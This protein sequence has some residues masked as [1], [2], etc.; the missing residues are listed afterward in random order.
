M[1][2]TGCDIHKKTCH[3]QHLD[4]D[5]ALGLSKNV[6]TTREAFAKFLARLDGPTTMTLEA[7]R[8]YWWISQFFAR[9]PKVSQTNVVDSRRG[10]KLAEE[11]SVRRGYGRAK[12][13][14]I[15][16]EMLAEQTRC[17]LAPTIHVPTP[18][19]LAVR[20]LNRHHL[21][22]RRLKTMA[23]NRIHGILSMHG[24][25][26][27]IQ[28]LRNQATQRDQLLRELPGYVELFVT[29]MLK[30][31]ELFDQQTVQC[32]QELDKILPASNPTIKLL[33]TAPGIGIVLARTIATEILDPSYL[34]E[35][36]Y[37]LSYAGL[38]PLQNESAGKKGPMQLNQ[39]CNYYLKYAFVAAAHG[40]RTHPRYRRKYEQD[41]KQHGKIRAK[42]NLAR[43]LAK[44][45]Y[46][47]LTRQQPYKF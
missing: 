33:M 16:A 9:H 7:T 17:G 44:A 29:N 45:V 13:D 31:M 37:L 23:A 22:L 42:L 5:G 21:M 4:E 47:M 18:P 32:D 46:W 34:R 30:Q 26:T 11:L 12:N 40:A 43:R 15:D 19:Q 41:I 39:F 28:M 10:R 6:P 3:L 1:Y 20:T 38:A 8:G 2:H 35:P 27:A 25:F 36:K 14:R 24:V